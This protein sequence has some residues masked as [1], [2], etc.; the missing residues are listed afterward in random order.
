MVPDRMRRMAAARVLGGVMFLAGASLCQP[1]QAQ[2]RGFGFQFFGNP[3]FFEQ[4]APAPRPPRHREPR[5]PASTSAPPP[6]KSDI[7]PARTGIVVGD[8]M[9]DWL[10]YGLE[11]AYAESTE[12]GV[13]RKVRSSAG[14]ID[15][16]KGEFRKWLEQNLG[17]EKPAF[18]AVMIGMNDRRSIQ[19]CAASGNAGGAKPGPYAF[20][21]KEWTEAYAKEIDEAISALKG[22]GVPVFWVGLPPARNIPASDLGFLNDLYRERAEKAGIGYVDVWDAFVDENGDFAMRG[23][24]VNGQTRS[25]RTAD[26]LNFTKPGA[27]KLALFL[28]REIDRTVLQAPA[29]PPVAG[30]GTQP[31]PVKPEERPV[32]GPVVPLG[33]QPAEKSGALLGAPKPGHSADSDSERRTGGDTSR[34]LRGRADDFT[35]PRPQESVGYAEGAENPAPDKVTPP[36]RTNRKSAPRSR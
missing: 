8:F 14:L 26:G 4:P 34:P 22:K 35:W 15:Q 12:I 7:K 2:Y 11:Q 21:A 1:A 31:Q 9:A 5:E 27:R 17:N 19:P 30:R 13:V 3:W 6:Q 36:P 32:A 18:I 33:R 16:C 28:E 23:P 29:P 25:L 24:D 10:A 20:R